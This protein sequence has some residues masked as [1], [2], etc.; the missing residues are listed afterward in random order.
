MIMLKPFQKLGAVQLQI[1][2]VLWR[3]GRATARQVT[4]EM[5]RDPRTASAHS[6][7]QTMLRE[8][9]AKGVVAHDV[10]ERT[11]IFFPLYE[12]A[13][14]RKMATEDLLIRLFG[15]SVYAMVEH[16]L[17]DE[18]LSPKERARLRTLIGEERRQED[19]RS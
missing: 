12:E 19:G 17:Q 5:N 4:D 11:F 10:E 8:L 14:I 2:K 9:E 6:S 18:R 15:G 16:L 7:V 3:L 13:E 1:M